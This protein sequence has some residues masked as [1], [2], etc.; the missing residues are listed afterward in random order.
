V[1]P[2]PDLRTLIEREAV[3]ET[4]TRLFVRTDERDWARE[5]AAGSLTD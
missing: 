5:G 3:I 2:V 1:S 4:V